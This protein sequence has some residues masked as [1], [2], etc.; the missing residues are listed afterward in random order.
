MLTPDVVDSAP[1]HHFNGGKG[2]GGYAK[3]HRAPAHFVVQIPDG[4]DSAQ[5]A[6]ML[7]GGVT[8]FAPLKYHKTGPGMTVGIVGVGGLGHYGVI[9]AKALGADRVVGISRREAKRQEVLSLGA[10]DYIATADEANWA[11][12]HAR[13]LDLIISTVASSEVPIA[14]YLSMLKRDGSFVQVGIPD[15]GPFKVNAASVVFGRQK[16]TGSMIGS[17]NDL[18]EMLELCASKGL[19]GMIQERPMS[20]ANQA[21]L[22]LEAGKPR[23]RYVLVNESA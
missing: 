4:L 8:V 16:F 7:C 15:D 17:P 3:Y 18:R 10:D 9:F 5:A 20:E 13:S 19:K 11:A 14:E 21:L 6:P 22:D 1:A 2:Q 23:Y 12:K